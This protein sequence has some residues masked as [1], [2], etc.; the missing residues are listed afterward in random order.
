MG[1][2]ADNDGCLPCH[3]REDHEHQVKWCPANTSIEGPV[4]AAT[5]QQQGRV[6]SA[7]KLEQQEDLHAQQRVVTQVKGSTGA[8]SGLEKECDLTTQ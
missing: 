5:H 1:S 7:C 4:H 2:C 3:W 8:G 6:G